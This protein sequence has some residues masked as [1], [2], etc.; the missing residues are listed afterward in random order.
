MYFWMTNTSDFTLALKLG[1]AP[2]GPTS[3]D[4]LAVPL[5][6]LLTGAF[7]RSCDMLPPFYFGLNGSFVFSLSS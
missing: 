6:K 1:P 4:V 3:Y 2:T 5:S 7:A